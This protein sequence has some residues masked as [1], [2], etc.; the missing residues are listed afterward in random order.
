MQGKVG[1]RMRIDGRE[2]L[3]FATNDYLGLAAD[4]YVIARTRAAVESFGVG[5]GMNP[6]LG[7]TSVHRELMDRMREFTG[8]EEVLLF[9]SCTAAN[10]ALI[11]TLIEEGDAVIS[12]ELN[13]ASIIDGCRLSRGRTIVYRHGDLISLESALRQASSA[14]LRLVVSDGVFSMEGE[15]ARLGRIVELAERYEAMVVVDESHAA[16]VIGPTG[17]GTFELFGLTAAPPVQTGTFSKAFGAGL[18][19]YVAGPRAMIEHL[20]D[21]ARSFIFTSGMPAALAAAALAAL[22]LM[23]SEPARL[24]LLRANLSHFRSGLKALG[25]ELLG[26]E[27]PIV[28]VLVRDSE[29]AHHLA[30][31]LLKLGVYVPAMSYPIVPEGAA[32]LR[33]QV[34]ASHTSSDIDEV[35]SA[36][37]RTRDPG[38]LTK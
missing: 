4:P 26:G 3:T 8:C 29:L 18:G 38:V 23:S 27:G 7:V 37:E 9:N 13:H 31:E 14:R 15:T 30:A 24:A 20:R 19:G 10:H 2:L 28:P 25:Y 34:S 33:A 35:I 1:A 22:D 12:D 16:G 21:R 5:S 6:V 11:A 32:R 17:R 36:F